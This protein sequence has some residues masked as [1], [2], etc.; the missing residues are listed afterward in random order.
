MRSTRTVPVSE[1]TP[2]M[3]EQ[4]ADKGG[5]ACPDAVP[6]QR[7]CRLGRQ[8]QMVSTCSPSGPSLVRGCLDPVTVAVVEKA[9]AEGAVAADGREVVEEKWQSKS[10]NKPMPLSHLF[11]DFFHHNSHTAKSSSQEEER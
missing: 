2:R 4:L 7:W 8:R 10:L 3:D 11:F 9:R 1:P 6:S 5:V